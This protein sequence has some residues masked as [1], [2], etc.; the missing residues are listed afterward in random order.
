MRSTL[1]AVLAAL[2]L[3]I[4]AAPTLAEQ[5]NSFAPR[6]AQ[7][8]PAEAP[9][10][11]GRALL[12]IKRQ[13]ALLHRDLA[14]LV[15]ALKAGDKPWAFWT[16]LGVSL[17]YGLFHAA[18]PGHGKVVISSYL[19]SHRASPAQGV[20]LAFGAAFAQALA[21]I[22]LV[23]LFV[24]VLDLSRLEATRSSNAMEAVSYGL[25]LLL[26]LWMLWAAL[27]GRH[28]CGHAHHHPTA[29]PGAGPEALDPRASDAV[30]QGDLIGMILAVGVRP[31]TGAVIV[32]LFTLSN[33]LLLAGMASTLAMAVGVGSVVSV[34]GV[35]AVYGRRVSLRLG[36]H[37]EA[38]QARLRAGVAIAGALLI[39]VVSG[40]MLTATLM[41]GAI[42][43]PLR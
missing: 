15:R 18:G 24:A 41:P 28:A 9:G 6:A 30:R 34:L 33:G 19:L 20:G 25:I 13:Q 14:G 23:G 17:L 10:L 12:E 2:T 4:A 43:G 29:S 35:L 3:L 11:V 42:A 5:G 36:G 26:G 40:V 32:L 22:V 37:S 8:V 39:V 21:A 27:R 16:L 7:A 31:C 1:V 38:W